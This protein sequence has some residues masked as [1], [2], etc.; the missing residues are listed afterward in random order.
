VGFAVHGSFYVF[1]NGE[2][3]TINAV[4]TDDVIKGAGPFMHYVLTL[5]MPG[6][7]DQ[8]FRPECNRGPGPPHLP[9]AG[10]LPL[11]ASDGTYSSR[12]HGDGPPEPP[13]YAASPPTRRSRSDISGVSR[14]CLP[15]G[16]T[17]ASHATTRL[18]RAKSALR[19]RRAGW[20]CCC[21]L[22]K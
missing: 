8:K 3:A 17:T 10:H 7:E 20:I 6:K 4:A 12:H 5:S 21:I 18:D 11:P 13:L 16:S 15:R 1:D 2:V 19:H 22:Q 14:R 9:G